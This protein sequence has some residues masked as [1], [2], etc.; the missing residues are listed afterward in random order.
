MS[1][2]TKDGASQPPA[3]R[4]R[5]PRGARLCWRSW[6]ESEA[7]VLNTLSGQTHYLD[8]LSAAVLGEIERGPA[9]VTHIAER[10]AG[11]FEAEPGGE[12][13]ARIDVICARFDA[14]GLADP[15]PS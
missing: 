10:I 14:L 4:W 3:G 9:T 11:A 12:L 13:P 6:D 1:D 15:E 8:A 7:I 5:L 2:S